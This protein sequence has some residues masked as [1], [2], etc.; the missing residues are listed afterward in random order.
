VA[1]GNADGRLSAAGDHTMS[2][3][4]DDLE[5]IFVEESALRGYR[6]N[7]HIAPRLIMAMALGITA[8][9]QW[10]FATGRVPTDDELKRSV[11]AYWRPA[12]R[13]QPASPVIG[14]YNGK[15]IEIAHLNNCSVVGFGRRQF[16]LM[17]KC[18]GVWPVATVDFADTLIW[19]AGYRYDARWHR[20]SVRLPGRYLVH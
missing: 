18:A 7:P 15:V 3:L 4:L 20:R 10:L 5:E 13:G 2:R 19:K 9:K 16:L 14:G 1:S 11:N 6:D 8:Q 12:V 17:P